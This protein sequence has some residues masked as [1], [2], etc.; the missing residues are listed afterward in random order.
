MYRKSTISVME[1]LEI[2]LV[3]ILSSNA[4]AQSGQILDSGPIGAWD[5]TGYDEENTRWIGTAVLTRVSGETLTGHIDWLGS[6]GHCGREYVTGSYDPMIRILKMSGTRTE[7]S[8][9]I[10][11]GNYIAELS[12]DG[13]RLVNGRW[14]SIDP[15][16]P[17]GWSG[18]RITFE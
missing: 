17:G 4:T 3:A 8:D 13:S 2:A 10:V 5:L 15:A 16:I 11:R 14:S 18:K 7:F 9:R 12:P 6:N 1:I